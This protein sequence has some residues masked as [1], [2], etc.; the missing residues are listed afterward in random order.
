[1][2]AQ[3]CVCSILK[4][5]PFLKDTGDDTIGEEPGVD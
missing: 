1:V 2:I 5:D 4:A 3:I